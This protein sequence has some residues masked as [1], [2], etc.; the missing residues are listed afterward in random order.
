MRQLI[1]TLITSQPLWVVCHLKLSL[2]N[3]KLNDICNIQ[4]CLGHLVMLNKKQ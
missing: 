2:L 4:K 1:L 3:G